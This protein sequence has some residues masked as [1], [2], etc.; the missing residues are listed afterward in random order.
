MEAK[1]FSYNGL[2]LWLQELMRILTDFAVFK[3]DNRDKE[4]LIE[5]GYKPIINFKKVGITLLHFMGIE[6]KTKLWKQLKEFVINQKLMEIP[7]L[8]E[9]YRI[10]SSTITHI[11]FFGFKDISQVE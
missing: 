7:L 3:E 2:I 4:K 6:V 5:E 9:L 10:P 8:F 11:A 1:K